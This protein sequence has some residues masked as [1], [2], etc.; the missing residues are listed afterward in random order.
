MASA[1]TPILTRLGS[2]GTIV[3]LW[4]CNPSADNQKWMTTPSQFP[5][6]VIVRNQASSRCLDADLGKLGFDGTKV[7]LW[8]CSGGDNQ[9]WRFFPGGAGIT[10]QYTKCL[11]AD[12][13][14]IGSVGTKVQLWACSAGADEQ[15]W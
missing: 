4:Q 1:W 9:A 12:T 14:T 5:D 10:V 2:N 13:N 11:D 8:D 7:Q 3:H 15:Q 6:K